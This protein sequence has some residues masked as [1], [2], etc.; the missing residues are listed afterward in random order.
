MKNTTLPAANRE[1][2]VAFQR[3]A[4]EMKREVE[5]AEGFLKDMMKKIIDIKYAINVT[6]EVPV[7]LMN[8]ADNISKELATISL[9]F[10]RSSDRPSFEEN[11]PSP[12]T[13]NER[14]GVLAYTHGRS[15]AS[16]KKMK[17]T[18]TAL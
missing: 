10:T 6:P 18:L 14:L 4:F 9:K 17:E 7:E 2:L 11:P 5:G 8:N 16:I 13:F 12:V 3:Q 15:T 1:E